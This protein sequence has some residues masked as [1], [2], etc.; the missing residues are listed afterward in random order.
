MQNKIN[1]VNVSDDGAANEET[2]T[3]QQFEKFKEEIKELLKINAEET[4]AMIFEICKTMQPRN[5]DLP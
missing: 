3:Q 4:R 2:N 1:V 5:I